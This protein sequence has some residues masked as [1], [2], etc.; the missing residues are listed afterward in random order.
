VGAALTAC[1]GDDDP[2]AGSSTT[3]ASTTEDATTTSSPPVSELE[4]GDCPVE[5]DPDVEVTCGTI[6][7]PTDHD[8]PEG[9]T[10][11]LAVATLRAADDSD[12]TQIFLLGG[13]PGEHTVV[14]LLEALTPDAPFLE[15]A[16]S[17]DVVA[18]D[19]FDRAIATVGDE[20]AADP[21]C[22]ADYPDVTENHRRP[23]RG[24]PARGEQPG[25]RVHA[26]GAVRGVG[27][28]SR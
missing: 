26:V 24:L 20:C 21:T 10:I 11:D 6:A 17:R 25:H 14:P 15:L 13:G 3:E 5:A 8:D 7:V 1:T 28:R 9:D 27:R 22:R 4:E 18:A 19:S 12:A 2:D 23:R 16:A